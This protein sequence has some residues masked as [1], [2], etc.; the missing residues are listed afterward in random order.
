M[1]LRILP[2]LPLAA[3][4][5]TVFLIG[6]TDSSD[7]EDQLDN[8]I[9]LL[10]LP[11]NRWVRYHELKSG[12]WWRKGH[13]GLAYDSTR[14]SLLVF[15]SDT[16]GDD[17]DNV[18]HEFSIRRREW[19]HHGVNAN[20]SSYRI[21]SE[22]YPVAGNMDLVPWAMHTY[23][24]VDYD[25]VLDALV[26][27]ASPDH[28]PIGKKLP[29]PQSHPIWIFKLKTKKWSIFDGKQGPRRY[30]GAA[31]AY[32]EENNNLFICKS[33]LWVL[34]L[35][36]EKVERIGKA[37]NCLHRTMVFDSWRR[38]I[39][40]FGSYRGTSNISRLHPGSFPEGSENW[41]EITPEGDYSPPYSKVPVAFDEK[42]GVFLLVVDDP[43]SPAKKKPGAATTFI[44]DPETNTYRKLKDTKIPAV[45]MNFMM[46][47]D[48]IHGVFFLLTG[49]PEDGIS[50]WVLRLVRN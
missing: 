25:R 35:K 39:N 5:L 9:F 38:N 45:G 43:K 49:N 3:I 7:I 36:K 27:V 47:W 50:V 17:W 44:Y 15:G 23:D 46:T 41:E 31:T 33:G 37:P 14:G 19:V 10:N 6:C 26:I 22:G 18:V 16:H 42:T 11:P 12:D 2:P 28:N 29:A 40:I 30:F 21:N 48:K 8:S 20:P 13:A 32:D 1:R 4:V 24:G 34:N